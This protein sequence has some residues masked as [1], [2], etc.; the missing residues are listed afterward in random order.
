[1]ARRN[2]PPERRIAR[3]MNAA[4]PHTPSDMVARDQ[5]VPGYGTMLQMTTQLIAEHIGETGVVLVLGA[6]GGLEIEVFSASM[7][8][9]TYLAIDPNKGMLDAARERA[10]RCG[11]MDKVV[12]IDG[13]VFNAPPA[14]C[15]AGVCLLTLHFVTGEESK[16]DTLKALRARLRPSAPLVVVDLCMDKGA[17]DYELRL[18]RY[19]RFALDS[20]ADPELVASTR[21]RVRTVIDTLGASREDALIRDAGF[22]DVD[23]FYAGHSWRG[24]IAR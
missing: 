9:W 8:R 5:F 17:S 18:D 11:A 3:L 13:F 14:L 15:D 6:G 22:R 2:R 23:L 7:P 1:M 19:C 21:E 16:L 12:W 10:R 4:T 20:G 24:W